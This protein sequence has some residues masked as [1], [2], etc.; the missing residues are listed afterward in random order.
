MGYTDRDLVDQICQNPYY[1]YFIGFS[2]FQHQVPF[3]CTLL[4]EWRKRVDLD[5]VKTANDLL[6]DATPEAFRFRKRKDSGS[7]P[8]YYE[9]RNQNRVSHSGLGQVSAVILLGNC[10][11]F[12]CLKVRKLA[13]KRYTYSSLGKFMNRFNAQLDVPYADTDLSGAGDFFRQKT[14]FASIS[15]YMQDSGAL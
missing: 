7:L 12:F 6:C 1:Q 5:F 2:A 8:G 13:G 9:A 3:A 11:Y 10:R 4:V 14:H 15:K